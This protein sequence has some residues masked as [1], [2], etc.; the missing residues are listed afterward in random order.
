MIGDGQRIAVLMIA[1]QKLALVIGTPKLIGFLAQDAGSCPSVLD[2]RIPCSDRR[3]YSRS[4]GR[5]RT[6]CRVPPLARRLA[7]N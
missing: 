3:S 6:P 4:Y 2:P 1:Q 5:C 7:T